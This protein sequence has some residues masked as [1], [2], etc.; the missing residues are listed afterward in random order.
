MYLHS[1]F[2]EL[3]RIKFSFFFWLKNEVFYT[4]VCL[5][6]LFS[7]KVLSRSFAEMSSFYLYIY[8]LFFIPNFFLYL[9]VLGRFFHF[10]WKCILWFM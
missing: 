7:V 6:F 10:F 4:C 5:Y 8:L 9:Y 3:I 2:K 1:V